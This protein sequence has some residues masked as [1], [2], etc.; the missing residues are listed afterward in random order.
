LG[1]L[2]R[3]DRPEDRDRD[4]TENEGKIGEKAILMDKQK[5]LQG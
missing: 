1:G 3:K 4:R 2:S 5:P